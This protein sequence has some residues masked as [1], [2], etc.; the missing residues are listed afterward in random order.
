MAEAP[1]AG[2]IIPMTE[3]RRMDLSPARPWVARPR[4]PSDGSAW[5]VVAPMRYALSEQLVASHISE[6][7]ARAIATAHEG[8]ELAQAILRRESRET[9]EALARLILERQETGLP[10]QCFLCQ[11]LMGEG[12][13]LSYDGEFAHADCVQHEESQ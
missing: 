7:D 9:L 4:V 12:D 5:E 1:S 11:E 8:V 10:K 3:G 2:R 6:W 13:G